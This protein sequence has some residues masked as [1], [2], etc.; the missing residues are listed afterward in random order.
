MVIPESQGS[1]ATKA[2]D[3]QSTSDTT[4][5]HS[6]E[7]ALGP[8]IQLPSSAISV[9]PPHPPFTPPGNL[10]CPA[11]AIPPHIPVIISELSREASSSVDL[12]RGTVGTLEH[13]YVPLVQ[14]IPTWLLELL[15][16]GTVPIKE[17]AKVSFVLR[18]YHSQESTLETPGSGPRR[19]GEL[20]G[21]NP[22]LTAPRMLRVR[23]VIA[24][25]VE[26]LALS[27]PKRTT[28]PI[29]GSTPSN[30]PGQNDDSQPNSSSASLQSNL[31][32][33]EEPH[34]N[35]NP[36]QSGTPIDSASTEVPVA[37][38]MTKEQEEE[39]EEEEYMRQQALRPENWLEILCNDQLL[40][41][42][43][44]LATIRAHFWK[45]GS[46]VVLTYRYKPTSTVP[47]SANASAGASTS[48][49]A[50]ATTGSL[51]STPI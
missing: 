47:G 38:A 32:K 50:A 13:D 39:E 35:G 49:L 51:H 19:L 29:S 33:G 23:K 15:L 4:S 37:V 20:P 44:T 18:P 48:T 17:S 9:R 5:S 14:V 26:K 3:D 11:I 21:G 41:P 36:S 25:V 6:V 2:D 1:G 22:R 45:S 8:A 46:D 24:H 28:A 10:E 30:A 16:K 7:S 12:Y 34:D 42:T 43:M 27:P 31:A 40:S